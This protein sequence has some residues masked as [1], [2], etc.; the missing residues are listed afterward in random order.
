MKHEFNKI[1]DGIYRLDV[2]FENL[3]TSVFLVEGEHPVL[4]DAATTR[5]D[6]E[7]IIVP[8]LL[9]KG[10]DRDM[11]GY[12]LVTH[13]HGDHSGGAKWMLAHFPNLEQVSLKDGDRLGVLEAVLLAGHTADSMGYIDTRTRSLISGDALQFFGVG[14][15]GCSLA[16]VKGYEKTVKKIASLE[17]CNLLL[18]HP[19]VGGAWESLG[20]EAVLD[21]CRTL[22]ESWNAVKTFILEALEETDDISEIKARYA[23]RFAGMPPLPRLTVESVREQR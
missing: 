18:S 21:L 17:L 5:T 20:K 6:V 9:A 13:R 12:L 14:G 10:Y 15:Y 22:E 16:T 7:E 19:F 1:T 11:R 4:I 2:P 23:E 3:Y 8:A